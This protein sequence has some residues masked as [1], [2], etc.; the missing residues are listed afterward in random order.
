[1]PWSTIQKPRGRRIWVRIFGTPLHAWGWEC[2]H[3]I[4]F[5]FG[6]LIFLDGQTERQERLDV[7][8]AQIAVTSW[9]FVDEVTEIKVNEEL[10][11]VRVVEERFG[12]IDLGVKRVEDPQNFTDGS[13]E[14]D[15]GSDSHEVN[16]E[17][18]VAVG[19]RVVE[20][21]WDDGWS[22]GSGEIQRSGYYPEVKSTTSDTLAKGEGDKIKSPKVKETI[23]LN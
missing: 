4:I 5:R 22:E 2:F 14:V 21:E 17:L 16:G 23:E 1:K 10:F 13:T 15:Y 7:A 12:E 6:R 11:V 20:D 19:G 3:R 9:D 8:R 18:G